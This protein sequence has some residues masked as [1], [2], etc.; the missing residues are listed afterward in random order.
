VE[1]GLAWHGVHALMVPFHAGVSIVP[2][3]LPPDRLITAPWH[4][5][6]AQV[7]AAV[8]V[9]GCHVPFWRLAFAAPVNPTWRMPSVWA[10]VYVP[11]LAWQVW[12]E[13]AFE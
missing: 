2:P 11:T 1:G 6:E 7:P 3:E 4:Q 10:V 8:P 5:V 12:H 9:P 13:S